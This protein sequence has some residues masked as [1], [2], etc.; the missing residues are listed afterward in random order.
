MEEIILK[1]CPFCG[2]DEAG[3]VEEAELSIMIVCAKCA[4]ASDYCATKEKAAEAWNT[5]VADDQ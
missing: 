2:A 5:R 3:F 4:A 1:P